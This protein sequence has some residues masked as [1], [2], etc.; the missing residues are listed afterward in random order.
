MKNP[1]TI[2]LLGVLGVL[3]LLVW[4]PW[5]NNQA[6]HDRFL[7][8]KARTDGTVDVRTGEVV[9]DY[10]VGWFP[11]GRYVASC[12]AGYFVPFWGGIL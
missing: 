5:M 11:F 4:A 3:V 2:T 12:D 6:I 9:C 10:R 7:E 8:E 1:F